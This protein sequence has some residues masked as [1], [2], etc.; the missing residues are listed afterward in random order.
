MRTHYSISVNEH[1]VSLCGRFGVAK[2]TRAKDNVTC[3]DCRRLL[4]DQRAS[5]QEF[6][7]MG[8][9]NEAHNF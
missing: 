2:A 1:H 7:G 5:V 4:E 6:V 3:K 9:Q 8:E